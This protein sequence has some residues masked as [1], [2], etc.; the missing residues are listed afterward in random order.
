MEKH[1][2]KDVEFYQRLYNIKKTQVE[3]NEDSLDMFE[4]DWAEQ[5][6]ESV[7]LKTE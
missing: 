4:R 5:R 7:K 3:I 1:S 6:E 2:W